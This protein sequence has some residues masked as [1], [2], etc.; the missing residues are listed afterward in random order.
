LEEISEHFIE[1]DEQVSLFTDS[2]EALTCIGHDPSIDVLLTC[3]DVAPLTGLELCWEARL[4]ACVRRPLYIVVM[5]PINNAENIAQALDCGADDLI[6]K[7]IRRPELYARLRVGARLHCAQLDLL[8]LA[9]TDVLTGL[10]NR[11]AFFERFRTA[12]PEAGSDESLSA[13]MFDI[14]HFK[15]VNDTHGHQLGDKVIEAVGHE[16]AMVD[17]IAGRLGGEEFA[18]LLPGQ[19]QSEALI[20][21]ETLRARFE[22]F[23]FITEAGPVTITCSFGISQWR[24]GDIADTLLRRADVALY[25]AKKKGR[26]LTC[27]AGMAPPCPPIGSSGVVRNRLR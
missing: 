6:S 9:E 13:I 19:T 10:F 20:V 3:L 27:V 25:E 16:T 21:A 1:R 7:P 4:K 26:N 17:G 18:I 2:Q 22:S 8:R 24:D 14:D 11:R 15:Q 23:A 5:S 12:L